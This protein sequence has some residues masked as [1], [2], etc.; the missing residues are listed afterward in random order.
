MA[1]GRRFDLSREASLNY[2]AGAATVCITPEEPLW[3]AG[4][5]A[6]TEPARETISDLYASGLALEDQTGE[7]FVI[8]SIDAIAVTPMI[9]DVVAADALARH[10][11]T[12]RQLLLTAT[13]TH[14]APEFRP[15]KQVF[16]KIPQGFAS[17][18]LPTAKKFAAALTDAIDQ[19]LDRLEPVHLF[20]RQ[21]AARFAHNRRRHGVV[22]GTASAD[23][24]VDH[25][26]PTLD[27]VDSR[28]RRKAIIFGYACHNTTIPP[29]DLRYCGD[30]AGFAA[31]QLRQENPDA[32]ALF[33]PG[34]GADE[35][36]EPQG[37]V[38]LS[39]RHGQQLA[40][41]VQRALDGA[42]REINGPIRA[43]LETIPLALEPISIE[44]LRRMADSDDEPQRVKADF[45]LKQLACGEDL[46]TSYAAPIQVVR[47]GKELLLIALSGEPVV[48]WA[49][50]LKREFATAGGLQ[51][52]R[53]LA[54]ASRGS[55][56]H[57]WVAG[58]SNDMFGY[59]PTRR[60]QVEGGYEG[61]RANLWS[62]IPAPFTADLEDRVAET[63]RRLVQRVSD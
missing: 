60:I 61:G 36:P 32:A 29:D 53:G 42:G 16:F 18:L 59:L 1:A 19:A 31:Q 21:T 7:R 37:S 55:T 26:V 13:H 54:E 20:F 9:A 39:R 62:S 25:D 35:D 50:K 10:G 57:V 12:R 28:G 6:R 30:W 17:K 22:G 56:S 41:A 46:I 33:I 49:H 4:Y 38:E 48:D 40:D 34:A 8:A 2:R 51:A 52:D 63:V 44:S 5:A 45:L 58:Y 47:F 11:L 43:G 27:C 3:L 15:E 23:D 14:Y 24:L